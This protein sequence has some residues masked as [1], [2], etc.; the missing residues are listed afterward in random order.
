MHLKAAV[1]RP[2]VA[3]LAIALV[4]TGVA[5]GAPTASPGAVKTRVSEATHAV[6]GVRDFALPA[7]TTHV[8]IHWSGH[9]DARVE[10]AFSGDGT[11]F[12]DPTE[13]VHD[14]FGE[15]KGDGRTYSV[16]MVAGGMRAVRVTTDQPLPDVT[17]MS[18]DAA[19]EVA[20]PLGFG[21]QAAAL[22][23]IPAV[24]P[25]H[26]WGAD[27]TIRFD[28]QGE[29]R[30]SRAF[31]PLQK[32]VIHHTAGANNDPNPA[33]TVRAI[34]HYHAVTLDWG[35]IGYEYLI[36][37]A[38][39]VYEGR[40]SRAYW[41]G[42]IPTADNEDGEV[43]EAGHALHHNPGS[44]GIA[45]LGNFT[46]QQPTAAARASLV[47]MLA[48][49]SAAHYIDPLGNSTYVNPVTGTTITTPN[50]T[51]HRDYQNTGCPG[52][53]FYATIPSIR[54]AVAAEISHPP[55][56]TYNPTR[57]LYFAAGTYT[58]RQFNSSGGITASLP[59]TLYSP[60]S[61]PTNQKSTIPNQSGNWYYMTAG[62]WAGYWIQESSGTT[63]GPAPPAQVA[64][65]Y[66]PWLPL[67]FDPGY[68][69]G[70]WFNTYGAVTG[71]LGYSLGAES[72]ATTTEKSTIPNQSGNWYYVTSG[73]WDGFW[74]QESPGVT[75][76]IPG[77]PVAEFSASPT[78]GIEQL[79]VAFTNTSSTFGYTS[80][81]WDF[82]TN[83]T[84]DSTERNPVWTYPT[85]GTYS[86]SL[87]ASNSYG[88]DTETK[89]GYV[90]VATPPPATF[91]P[92]PPARILD[93]RIGTG[94]AGPFGAGTPRTFQVTGLGG[95]PLNATAVT[96]NL[97]VTNPTA[98]GSV[99]LGPNPLPSPPSSTL[100]V[101]F[102]DTRANGVTVAL[103]PGGTLSA[104]YSAAG[105]GAALVFDVTGYFVPDAT[106]ATFVPLAPARILDTRAGT[107]L[108][109]PFSPHSP[110]TF[111]VRG[112]AGVSATATAVTGNLTVT[113]QTAPGSVYLGP[114]PLASPGSSTLNFPVGDT[115]AN[116]VTVALSAAGD[117][118]LTFGAAAGTADV[119]F[120]VTGYFVP[121]G[122]GARFVPLT[123]ARLLDTRVGNGLSGPFSAHSPRAFQ[124]HGRGGVPGAATGVTGNLT[125][126]GPTASGW[127]YLGPDPLAS[128]ASSTLNFP[129]GDTRA[130]GLTVALGPGGTL[131]AT[132]GYTGTTQLI[133]D[134][135]GYFVP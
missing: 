39:R 88:T 74:V 59:Y 60:S 41:N 34:Y 68:Y 93:T 109:G 133:F 56:E 23:T 95:V 32:L 118:S 26:D 27:E 35:D 79:W 13:V 108:S 101:P 104:T 121:D 73:I 85:A 135:T 18:M 5:P 87:T 53:P 122:S 86:V 16:V 128:P 63:L 82:D 115:R 116:G 9:H 57:P 55:I 89:A 3:A 132:S 105:G 33:A 107:G 20:A 84:T 106:G 10:V 61:A 40:Y 70:Y 114:D 126:T 110:R 64:E 83:G 51:G 69:V 29:E 44:M 8:A 14:E 134:V 37:A 2:L 112:Q 90:T 117:L 102:A 54:S 38:G 49:A 47:R 81:A 94:L 75:L 4:L 131:S 30:W 36:D 12:L 31:Y 80:W 97:T 46:S 21:A 28:S 120:D 123:P 98:P 19:G 127:A 100:N 6:D 99:Y 1:A 50:I 96:G 111:A 22:S 91:V 77:P 42:A 129:W 103:G 24:I 62:V 52:D 58:G 72:R 119:V 67:R 66:L 113:N 48:W 125:V 25:R 92:L 17:V 43:V 124:V 76:E 11:V 7:G 65:S 71:S 45:L 15:A 130:N 78:A